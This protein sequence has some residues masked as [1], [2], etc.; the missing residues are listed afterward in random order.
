MINEINTFE[1]V[2]VDRV[3]YISSMIARIMHT[4]VLTR[5]MSDTDVEFWKLGICKQRREI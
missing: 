3:A 5:I 1:Y 2:V 4:Y